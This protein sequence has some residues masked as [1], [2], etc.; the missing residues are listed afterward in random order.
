MKPSLLA[1]EAGGTKILAALRATQW[2]EERFVQIPSTEPKRA[3]QQ[4]TQFLDERHVEGWDILAVGVASFGPIMD[5]VIQQSPKQEWIGFDWREYLRLQLDCPIRVTTDVNAAALAEFHQRSVHSLV[6]VTVGTGIGAGVVVQGEIWEGMMH[7]EAGH[8]FIKRE[9]DDDFRGI[10]PYHD[11]CWEGLASGP[12][13]KTRWERASEDLPTEH[14]AWDLEARYLARGCL[15]LCYCLQPQV[16]VLGGGV[17][18][19]D[20]LF[21]KVRSY[22]KNFSAG[23][24]GT[25]SPMEDWE[26]RLQP[27][28]LAHSGLEGAFLLAQAALSGS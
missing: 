28:S 8:Q 10:C 23:Y 21:P 20:G 11:D 7:P 22:I 3:Q 13:I 2:Q 16:L 18:A 14:L 1:I 19:K 9:A 25:N 5:G 15:N 12:A 6:Y 26:S 24:L 4:L 27:P 17:M